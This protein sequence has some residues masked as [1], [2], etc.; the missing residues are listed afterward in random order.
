ML[1]LI[2]KI[3]YRI[4]KYKKKKYLES[5]IQSGLKIGNNVDIMDGFFLDPTHCYLIRIG[6]NCV[7]A[8]NVRL[9]A[10]DASMKQNLGYTRVGK[11]RIE[12]GCF[13]GDSVIILPGIT[14]GKGTIVGA[15]S[16]VTKDIP[17]ASIASGNPCR[18]ICN[19]NEFFQKHDQGIALHKIPFAELEQDKLTASQQGEILKFLDSGAGYVR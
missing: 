8:P 6:D 11:I 3:Y 17:P 10:H 19:R 13:I 14:I 9:I 18:V 1:K 2:R 12:P 7:L 4:L 15:G 16:I 5:L